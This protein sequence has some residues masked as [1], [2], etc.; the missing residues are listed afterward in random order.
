MGKKLRI[1][2]IARTELERKI[3]H[4]SLSLL[5]I[6]PYFWTEL[7]APIYF[8]I[9]ALL[10]N[11]FNALL[12]KK[13]L[14]PQEI[15]RNFTNMRRNIIFAFIQ[16]APQPL[17][18]NLETID[19]LFEKIEKGIE[20]EISKIERNYEKIGGYIGIT[21]GVLGVLVSEVLFSKYTFYGILALMIVD[22]ASSV[23]SVF[24][25]FKHRL[26]R[27]WSTLEGSITAFLTFFLV[28]YTLGVPASQAILISLIGVITEAYAIEDNLLIPVIVSLSAY[29]L[30][31][32]TS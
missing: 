1:D 26:P 15:K 32:P 21:H 7:N 23:I 25:K 29:I 20:E 2:E 19:L 24:T 18:K 10:A 11:Y 14:L 12:L 27:S 9:I 16:R 31:L 5:L 30:L 4:I 3:L 17:A 22:P 28:L 6:L 8:A 13:P